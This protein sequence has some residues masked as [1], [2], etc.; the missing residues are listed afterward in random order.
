MKKDFLPLFARTIIILLIFAV[1]LGL[2]VFL[3]TQVLKKTPASLVHPSTEPVVLENQP[4]GQLEFADGQQMTSDNYNLNVTTQELPAA[5]LLPLKTASDFASSSATL[6]TVTTS[7]GVLTVQLFPQEAPLTVANFAS[8]VESGFYDDL[9]F[10]RVEPGFV[11]QIGDS[12][13]RHATSEAELVK[14]GTNY[15]GY[16][17]LDEISPALSH[18]QKGI[19]SMANI[20]ING[21]YPHSGG[22]Q[23]FI[24]L[25][26]ATYLD[27]R[28]SIFGQV[29]DGL[30]VL[31][32]LQIGDQITSITLE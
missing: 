22:S 21:Q 28:Y 32:Q 8:L 20:N 31:D 14:L 12:A 30:D 18:N 23:F 6:A 17:I 11:V 5:M 7:K 27:G 10:H 1:I 4:D 13:S 15:P 19:L 16:R 24:T 2:S 25:A 9:K 26:P 29:T 3:A